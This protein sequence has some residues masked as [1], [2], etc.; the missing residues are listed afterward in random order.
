M[1]AHRPEGAQ[2]RLLHLEILNRHLQ[3]REIHAQPVLDGFEIFDLLVQ[4]A[5]IEGGG[6]HARQ[7]KAHLI[8]HAL[9]KVQRIVGIVTHVSISNRGRWASGAIA[10]AWRR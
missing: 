3:H 1:R 8:P 5:F 9:Q 4:L 10:K 7:L 2:C 6:N